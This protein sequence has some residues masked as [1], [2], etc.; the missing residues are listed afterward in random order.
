[1]HFARPEHHKIPF[2]QHH[3]FLLL[4]FRQ[5][6]DVFV[7]QPVG[8]RRTVRQGTE[9]HPFL[10]L[11]H[12]LNIQIACMVFSTTLGERLGHVLRNQIKQAV[13]V[14]VVLAGRRRVGDVGLNVLNGLTQLFWQPGLEMM[15]IANNHDTTLRLK[16]CFIFMFYTRIASSIPALF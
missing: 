5:E 15:N 1:M 11:Q 6:R 7:R 8:V 14:D 13:A 10:P 9:G 2:A 12:N 3:G 16:H 4:A